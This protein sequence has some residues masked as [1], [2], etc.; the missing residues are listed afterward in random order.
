VLTE[1]LKEFLKR[2]KIIEL[3]KAKKNQMFFLVQVQ[4]V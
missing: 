2:E 4:A 1:L 3:K